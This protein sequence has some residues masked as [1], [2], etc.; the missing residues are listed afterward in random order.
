MRLE[1]YPTCS[2]LGCGIPSAFRVGI[3]LWAK[4]DPEHKGDPL[5]L[6]LT[7]FVCEHHRTEY[8]QT[9]AEMLSPEGTKDRIAEGVAL[10]GRAPPDFDSAAMHFDPLPP[11]NPKAAN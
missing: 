2:I 9:A 4:C 1:D 10:M 8:P 7:M 5:E 6:A 11:L 3:L